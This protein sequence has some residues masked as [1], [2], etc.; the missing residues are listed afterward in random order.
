MRLEATLDTGPVYAERRLP[1]G[2]RDTA[3]DLQQRLAALGATAMIQVIDALA[4]GSARAEAQS[5][6]GVTYA[7][8]LAKH[9]ALIDWSG[10]AAQISRQVRSFNPW[11]VA[12]TTLDDE[13]IRIWRAHDAVTVEHA[14]DLPPGTVIGLRD[15]ALHVACGQG[16][17]V[18]ETLQ[19]SGRRVIKAADFAHARAL[20]G[21]RFGAV[22]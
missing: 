8:K 16:V 15:T 3:G 20:A 6:G 14:A 1:I 21:L 9:E 17:L 22:S 5:A 19:L 7:S 11:P 2:A 18:I 10:S 4:A 13:R 12:E